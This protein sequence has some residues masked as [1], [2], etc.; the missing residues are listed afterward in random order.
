M[1]SRSCLSTKPVLT[2]SVN[3]IGQLAPRS[4]VAIVRLRSLGDCVLTTPAIQLLKE[5]RPD[6]EITVVAEE[7]F[8]GVFERAL[9]P[10]VR[11][12]RGF[13][14]DLCLNFHGGTR[15]ARLTLLSGARFRAGFD[16]FKPGAI[17]NV[18][19]PTAQ[20]TLGI[21]RRVHTAEHMASAMFYLGVPVQDVPRARM[22]AAPGRSPLAPPGSYT[23]IHPLAATPEKTW[24][25]FAKLAA[26]LAAEPVF[27]G[28][29]GEDLS[30]F[31]PGRTVS[32]APLPEL[33]RLI[34]DA[35]LFIGNDSGPAHIAAAF[36]VPGLVLFGP[37]DEETWAPWRAP[38][39][40][41][42]GVPIESITIN[43]ARGA[44]GRL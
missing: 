6:L 12:I 29:P 28:G 18:P 31:A 21:T 20:Q 39:Q 24:P 35:D 2:N 43:E 32:G 40:V 22:P 30:A 33:A 13:A 11:A 34:R 36:G 9:E 7:R 19:I 44:L 38:S 37:S 17:Y 5:A 14:P 42:K 8:A 26:T 1:R 41:L 27:I 16:I 3:I 23:V 15:S 4:R 25:H 10:S